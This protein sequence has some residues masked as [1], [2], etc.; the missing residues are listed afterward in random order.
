M[1][2]QMGVRDGVASAE[3]ESITLRDK[4]CIFCCTETLKPEFIS[5]AYNRTR[6]SNQHF[7]GSE[8]KKN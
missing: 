4:L 6:H 5:L 2:A 3:R 1:L 8:V 7:K